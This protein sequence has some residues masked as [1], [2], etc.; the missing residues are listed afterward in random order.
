MRPAVTAFAVCLSVGS[1]FA[2]GSAIRDVSVSRGFFN[3]SLGQTVRISLKL[4]H[5]GKLSILILDRDGYPVRSLVANKPTPAGQLSV[6]WDGKDDRGEVVP[7]EAYS[8]RIDFAGAGRRSSYFPGNQPPHGYDVPPT[9][10]DRRGG[11]L[12]Y[13]LEGPARVHLQAGCAMIDPKTKEPVGPVLKT[14]VNREPRLGGSVVESWNGYDESGTI[15]VPDLPH[16]VVGIAATALPD[17]SIIT[18]GNRKTTFLERAAHRR[19]HSLFS[20]R[21]TNHHHHLGLTALQDVSPPLEIRP[22]AD[23]SQK[24]RRWKVRGTDLTLAVSVTGLTASVFLGEPGEVTAY[25]DEKPVATQRRPENGRVVF[26]IPASKLPPGDHVIAVNW[27]SDYGPVA[28]NAIRVKSAGPD[29]VTA[30]PVRMGG[31]SK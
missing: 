25:V 26:R 5:A 19:G 11:I 31:G 15:F 1:L 9:Y 27:I 30:Q 21:D 2:Q 16:F 23:W 18:I 28:V 24:S 20:V 3:P 8:T 4:A 7:D 10:Y 17:N 12:A 13:R 22:D 29:K 6:P 14:V